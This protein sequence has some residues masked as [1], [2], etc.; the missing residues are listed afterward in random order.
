MKV[1]FI[2]LGHMG[3]PMARNLL[4]AGHEVT[5][6]NR[7]RRKAEAL[8][9]AGARIAERPADAC[10]GDALIT[11]LT[12]DEALEAVGWGEGNILGALPKGGLH[13]GMSTISV[14]LSDRLADAHGER[15]QLYL[16]APV[17]GRPEAAAA[18]K[19]FIL[20][21]GPA[22]GMSRAEPL[23]KAL[24]Q[25]V[26]TWGDKPSAANLVKLSANFLIAAMIECLGEA[27]AL[28]RKGGIDPRRYVEMLT[29]TLFA[30]P[31][32]KTYGAIIADEKF[33]PAGFN[34][35]MGFK[36]VRL[37]L[38]AAEASRVPMPAASVVRDHFIAGLAQGQGE[39]DWAAL[40]RIIASNAGL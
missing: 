23:F 14:A 34:M 12:G 22:D 21:A 19:L 9:E 16:A 39:L 4:E 32:Y 24:G 31:V 3:E 25:Q 27:M 6:F 1:G 36:D 17:L 37:A 26:F 11:M 38:A 2:G 30:A 7:T 10:R 20:A 8:A 29:T 18:A 15:G 28:V 5:V 35:A 33:T 13:I 40:S